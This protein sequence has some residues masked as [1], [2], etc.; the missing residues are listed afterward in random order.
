MQLEAAIDEKRQTFDMSI[1]TQ[2]RD[3]LSIESVAERICAAMENSTINSVINYSIRSPVSVLDLVRG[4]CRERGSDA[5]L[6]LGH[7][8]CLN[9]SHLNFEVFRKN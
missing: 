6:N 3:Y 2:L 8:S 1:G 4:R 5:H 9:T 7:F